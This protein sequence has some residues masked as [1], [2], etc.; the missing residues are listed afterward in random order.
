VSVADRKSETGAVGLGVDEIAVRWEGKAYRLTYE[1]LLKAFDRAQ[2]GDL[3]GPHARF[4][5]ELDGEMKS[6]ESVFREVVPM[7][8][9]GVKAEQATL[10]AGLFR[11]LGFEVLDRRLCHER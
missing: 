10:V 5:V 4:Y 3:V 7:G 1:G 9:D 8:K 11:S 2:V 6:V